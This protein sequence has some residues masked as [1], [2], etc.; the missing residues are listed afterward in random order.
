MTASSA[1]PGKVRSGWLWILLAVLLAYWPLATFQ[2]SLS[3]GD[4][5][6][7][8]LP[9]RHYI[10]SALHDGQLPAWNPLQQMGYPIHADLQGPAWYPEAVLLGGTLGQG[11][12][13]LQLLYLAYLVIGGWGMR[14]L[15]GKLVP[16]DGAAVIVGM[17]YA[18]SGFFTAHAMHFYAVISAAWLP[19]L[20]WSI[21]DLLDRPRPF[22]A[23]RTAILLFLLLTGG[24]HTFLLI[25]AYPL[26][27]IVLHGL[28]RAAMNDRPAL[29]RLVGFGALAIGLAVV[30]ACG[31]LH[32]VWEVS[33]HVARMG[34]LALADAE[35]SSFTL[36][37]LKSLLW[38]AAA[39]AGADPLGTDPT[40]ANG[41]FGVVLL[42][43]MLPGLR[44]VSGF[45][46]WGLLVF[47]GI[48]ALAALGPL[49]PMHAWLWRLVP[50]MD[51][52]RFPAYFW[53]FT[54]FG[55]LPVAAAGM[56]AMLEQRD[57]RALLI[58]VMLVALATLVMVLRNSW[59]GWGV[60]GAPLLERMRSLPIASLMLVNGVLL[61]GVL[62]LLVLWQ[63]SSGRWTLL[64]GLVAVEMIA[65]IQFTQW[66][67]TLGRHSPAELAA[68]IAAQPEGPVFPRLHAMGR[69]TDDSQVMHLL[70]RNVRNFQGGPSHGGFNSFWLSGH[71]RLE[72][73]HPALQQAMLAQPFL[74]LADTLYTLP[75]AHDA[76]VPGAPAAFAAYAGNAMSATAPG[77]VELLAFDHQGFTARVSTPQ[78]RFLVVQQNLYPGW[79][80]TIDGTP[81]PVIP[82]N[83]AAFG[84]WVPA[85]EHRVGI[86]YQK[87]V[88]RLLYGLSYT[89]FFALLLAGA[90]SHR[91]RV[92]ALGG[93]VLLLAGTLYAFHG[94]V[95]KQHRM[96]E[97]WQE[98]LDLVEKE[99]ALTA[100]V[101]T[102][103]PIATPISG[104]HLL[105]IDTPD[106]MEQLDSLLAALPAADVLLLAWYGLPLNPA[107]RAHLTQHHGYIAERMVGNAVAGAC[108]FKRDVDPQAVWRTVHQDE[109]AGGQALVEGPEPWTPA[110]RVKIDRLR[111]AGETWLLVD[112][113]YRGSSGGRP[114]LVMERR[115]NGW[116][117][118]HETIPLQV[119]GE[120]RWQVFHAVRPIPAAR[121]GQEELGVYVLNE[122]ADT[123]WVKDL[124]VRTGGAAALH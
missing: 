31:T 124:R 114:R 98:V 87:P 75:P 102:D 23:G 68:R 38:P 55:L 37:A 2:Y 27:A 5:L 34:G 113:R 50:G 4:T 57:R 119:Q 67:T 86:R 109:L 24:N 33:P 99:T 42:L 80:I 111:E 3:D 6:D 10:A 18:L 56:Q 62:V 106:G 53:Y 71:Q 63:R 26:L 47:A 12:H 92:P 16:H 104:A 30:M 29:P 118:D 36:P 1:A 58:A 14:R 64:A 61:L 66:H 49:L 84:S 9:W 117:T 85:G 51:L 7:C 21:L 48:C 60:A 107:M 41:Y 72:R 122:S 89:T 19:W 108:L 40:M 46:M 79:S 97:G 17:A 59:M 28:Y 76:V 95:P 78:E 105:R 25:A 120:Q 69:N 90:W 115:R 94:H 110:Y 45:R 13:V 103:R 11:P 91:Q 74:Y 52:F 77:E 82:V 88:L 15:S 44:R 93:V 121:Y 35:V 39:T 100:V 101:N 73:E 32:A 65:A 123:V 81:A 22:A 96:E 83:I 8:W 70:W 112:L 116:I 54:L 20:F 43:A